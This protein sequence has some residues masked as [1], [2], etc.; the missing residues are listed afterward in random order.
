MVNQSLESRLT[1]KKI[2][3]GTQGE[4]EPWQKGLTG[5]HPGFLQ[6]S[7]LL[8]HPMF[9]EMLAISFNQNFH[10]LSLQLKKETINA[11]TQWTAG[12]TT[13]CSG[14]PTCRATTLPPCYLEC[15]NTTLT[16]CLWLNGTINVF[17][18]AERVFHFNTELVASFLCVFAMS[19]VI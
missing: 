1:K 16:S 14:T 11:N 6:I 15:C 7:F 5:S 17:S 12:C 13:N 18:S 8:L 4:T 3:G 2:T 10:L 9:K 19:L